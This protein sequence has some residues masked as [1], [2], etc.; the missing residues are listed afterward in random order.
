MRPMTSPCARSRP[1]LRVGMSPCELGLLE[2]DDRSIPVR[3]LQRLHDLAGVIRRLV[4]DDDDLRGRNRLVQRREHARLDRLLFVVGRDDDRDRW[5]R[6]DHAAKPTPRVFRHSVRFAHATARLSF[7]CGRRDCRCCDRERAH[8]TGRRLAREPTSA[9][10]RRRAQSCPA[11]STAAPAR[12]LRA[13]AREALLPRRPHLRTA[14]R[15]Q[16]A[17]PHRGRR[18][19]QR[20]HRGLCALV[21]RDRHARHLLPQRLPPGLD[22]ARR[23]A[24]PAH[25]DRAD[26][27]GE[28]HLDPQ[29]PAHAG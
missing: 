23:A 2:Q 6:L 9:S 3:L 15:R 5:S 4:V 16:P 10:Q 19:Q 11:P 17:G 24:R 27:D 25:R 20:G 18:R 29:R 26:P 14:R 22:R 1:K 8:R 28:P 12:L 7:G 13:R 21:R